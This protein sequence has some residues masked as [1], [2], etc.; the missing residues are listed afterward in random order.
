MKLCYST[1]AGM[2]HEEDTPATRNPPHLI[3]ALT[4][5]ILGKGSNA[6]LHQG[7]T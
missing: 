2:P 4:M 5:P 6:K 3:Y 7:S 1:F